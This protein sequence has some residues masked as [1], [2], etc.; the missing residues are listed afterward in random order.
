MWTCAPSPAGSATDPAGARRCASTP[1]GSKQPTGRG[2]RNR[3]APA[4]PRP[5]PPAARHPYEVV[6]AEL[7][8]QIE[9]GALSPGMP[10]PTSTKL[11]ALHDV[12]AGTVN[13]AIA[14]LKET[15]LVEASRGRRAQVARP[16]GTSL[17]RPVLNVD[18]SAS[19]VA[20]RQ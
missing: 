7:R 17:E 18:P 1:R 9:S 5:N 10:L 4:H 13:R 20:D 15:G 11:V 12:S 6:A 2:R 19:W 16:G 14:L 8:N 3:N